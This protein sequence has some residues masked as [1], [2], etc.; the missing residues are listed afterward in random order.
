MYVVGNLEGLSVVRVSVR[1]QKL[2]SNKR[3]LQ[4]IVF[5]IPI[6]VDPRTK[7]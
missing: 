6:V 7:M 2:Y 4:T 5:G 1:A 3:I